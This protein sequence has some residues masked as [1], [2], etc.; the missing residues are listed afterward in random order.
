M[1]YNKAG[2]YKLLHDADIGQGM[3][4]HSYTNSFAC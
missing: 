3:L 4:K 1:N 2:H